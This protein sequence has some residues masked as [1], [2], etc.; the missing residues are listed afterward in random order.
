VFG[1]EVVIG[2]AVVFDH[3]FVQSWSAFLSECSKPSC[4]FGRTDGGKFYVAETFFVGYHYEG[5]DG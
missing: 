4:F 3:A 2:S 5:Y 1:A